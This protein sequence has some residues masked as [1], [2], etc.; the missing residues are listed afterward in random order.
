MAISPIINP[1]VGKGELENKTSAEIVS[2][3]FV[4]TIAEA[5]QAARESVYNVPR[6]DDLQPRWE[7]MSDRL[8]R[9]TIV[10]EAQVQA[11]LPRKKLLHTYTES[12]LFQGLDK[13]SEDLDHE[14]ILLAMEKLPDSVS[15]AEKKLGRDDG[16]VIKERNPEGEVYK[17]VR[18]SFAAELTALSVL[19]DIP[20]EESSTNKAFHT[21]MENLTDV[22]NV[23]KAEM[24]AKFDA[25]VAEAKRIPGNAKS[26]EQSLIVASRSLGELG[27]LLRR[28]DIAKPLREHLENSDKF[29]GAIEDTVVAERSLEEIES[30]IG[31]LN[32][33]HSLFP[34]YEKVLEDLFI[35]PRNPVEAKLLP[36][37]PHKSDA[38]NKLLDESVGRLKYRIGKHLNPVG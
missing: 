30:L 31:G 2:A 4:S 20:L 13:I 32:V 36:Y 6:K 1:T 28:Q 22:P 21:L 16:K 19:K 26:G 17:G 27:T 18:E 33:D 37:A 12:L 23:A 34:T 7:K 5:A 29:L 14:T 15:Q 10:T 9:A 35:K 11:G 25:Y 24:K 8:A 38:W 3:S